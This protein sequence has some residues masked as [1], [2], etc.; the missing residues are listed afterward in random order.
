ML[1]FGYGYLQIGKKKKNAKNGKMRSGKE[2]KR[3]KI[4]TKK[5]LKHLQNSLY[6]KRSKV[7]GM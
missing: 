1:Y 5:L 3:S 4:K 7:N 6:Q 2:L